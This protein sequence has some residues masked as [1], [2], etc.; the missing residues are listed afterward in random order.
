MDRMRAFGYNLLELAMVA[1]VTLIAALS[2]AQAVAG[3]AGFPADA[4]I[5]L[6]A[7]FTGIS[8]VVL[9]AKGKRSG[10]IFGLVNAVA[11]SAI[12]YS[13]Q[14]YGEVMLNMLFYVPMNVAG[15]AVWARHRDER[16]EGEVRARSLGAPMVALCAVLIAAATVA[17]RSLLVAMGGS[18]AMLDGMST[19]LSIFATVLMLLR[20]SE[21]WLCW[22]VVDVVTVAL[23]CLAGDPV[24]VA[25]WGAYLLNAFYGFWMWRYKAG[26]W[27]P[28]PNLAER[29]A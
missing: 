22:I 24:M 5:D 14:Y 20:F 11:Y 15:F 19:V 10:F 6:L 18:M 2:F 28:F 8:S 1:T 13:T 12:S 21:Q 16:R 29:L 26:Q 9:T 3:G 7:S 17:Y 23:W 4:A 25:M 27:V